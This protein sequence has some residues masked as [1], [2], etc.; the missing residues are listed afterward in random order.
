[1]DQKQ[2]IIGY[3]IE[4]A[5]EHMET[6]EKGLLSLQSFCDDP[7][8]MNELFRAAHSVK[9]G[10][11]ML[12]FKAVGHVAHRMEDCFKI[13]KENPV[14]IDRNIE[15]LFLKGFDG[16]QDL[17]G[18]ISSGSEG[19]Q[20]QA[21][22][23]LEPVFSKLQ[24]YLEKLSGKGPSLPE[25]FNTQ[26]MG[27]LRELL[28]IFKQPDGAAARQKLQSHCDRLAEIGAASEQWCN[29]I[30]TTKGAIGNPQASFKVLAPLV[31]TELKDAAQKGVMGKG[32]EIQASANLKK[33]GSVGAAAAPAAAAPAAAAPA[34][35][36]GNDIILPRDVRGAAQVLVKTFDR[37]Q[38]TELAQILIKVIKG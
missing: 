4:E 7:E 23:Q 35:A 16:L 34:A 8:Q 36:S 37:K 12:G 10:A 26:V 6:I 14:P 32:A 20:E 29:L 28:G 25:D 21:T 17:L 13:L 19:Q 1:M 2:Q 3:F 30:Q 9:G 11:N 22:Q 24:V 33:L 31:I 18:S 15:D 27:V 5:R 38:L